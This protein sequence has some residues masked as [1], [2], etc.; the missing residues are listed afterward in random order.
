MLLTADDNYLK[1][2][3]R[4]AYTWSDSYPN[5]LANETIAP[6]LAQ[7]IIDSIEESF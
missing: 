7:F 5:T 1:Y 4:R 3:Y 2:D 6:E